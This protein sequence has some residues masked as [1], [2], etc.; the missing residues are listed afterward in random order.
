MFHARFAAAGE[1]GVN[2]W[3]QAVEVKVQQPEQFSGFSRIILFQS[4][5]CSFKQRR[6][7]ANG[8]ANGFHCRRKLA[9]LLQ[10]AQ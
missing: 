9:M 5:A 3:P 2:Q 1:Q 6:R 7:M 8:R 4:G 10:N